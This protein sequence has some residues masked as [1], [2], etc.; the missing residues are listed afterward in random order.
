[1]ADNY[2][3]NKYEQYQARQ[4]RTIPGAQS[5]MA[6]VGNEKE[7]NCNSAHIGCKFRFAEDI[8]AKPRETCRGSTRP[9]RSRKSVAH[10]SD[11]NT[12]LNGN[13]G[14]PAPYGSSI[15]TYTISALLV[16]RPDRGDEADNR[17]L[18]KTRHEVRY[19]L[20]RISWLTTTGTDSGGFHI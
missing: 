20:H 12:F 4:I 6:E 10:G 3:E 19:V 17:K 7:K 8:P 1:M 13:T 15:G 9:F 18:G 14:L 5:R 16:P 11:S 2:I